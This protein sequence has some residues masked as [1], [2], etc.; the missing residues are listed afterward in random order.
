MYV[1]VCKMT[2]KKLITVL[3]LFLYVLRYNSVKFDYALFKPP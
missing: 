1:T 3:L 2:K